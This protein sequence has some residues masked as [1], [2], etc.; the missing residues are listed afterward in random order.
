MTNDFAFL[1]SCMVP[2]YSIPPVVYAYN[3]C[4]LCFGHCPDIWYELTLYLQR[5]G[6][7]VRHSSCCIIIAGIHYRMPHAL[8]NG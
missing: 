7:S 3:Q 1:Q 6:E 4:L 8:S 2:S 5:A